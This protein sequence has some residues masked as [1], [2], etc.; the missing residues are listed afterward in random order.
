MAAPVAKITI[1]FNS[2]KFNSL[3]SLVKVGA[4]QKFLKQRALL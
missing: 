1:K 2:I 4:T 3:G